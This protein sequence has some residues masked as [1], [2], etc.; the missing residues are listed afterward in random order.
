MG[1]RAPPEIIPGLPPGSVVQEG[2]T[3]AQYWSGVAQG[4]LG[5]GGPADLRSPNAQGLARCGSAGGGVLGPVAGTGPRRAWL[6]GWCPTRWDGITPAEAPLGRPVPPHGF[7]ASSAERPA[8]W[9]T[10]SGALSPSPLASCHLFTVPAAPLLGESVPGAGQRRGIVSVGTVTPPPH[11]GQASQ[12]W[13]LSPPAP[14]PPRAQSQEGRQPDP[15]APN[16][17]ACPSQLPLP[18]RVCSLGP[19]GHSPLDPLSKGQGEQ[20]IGGARRWRGSGQ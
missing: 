18:F 10:W 12:S 5:V 3:E 11:S 4:H 8:S 9:D 2:E 20:L 7:T 1:H 6:S 16:S 14:S 19:G 15:R 17:P 13:T